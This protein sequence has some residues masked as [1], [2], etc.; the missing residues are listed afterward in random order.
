M[1]P[2]TSAA[3][4]AYGTLPTAVRGVISASVPTFSPK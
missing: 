2:F 1:S 3:K 4:S